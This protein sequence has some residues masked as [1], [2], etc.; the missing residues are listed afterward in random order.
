MT[1]PTQPSAEETGAAGAGEPA[2]REGLP[3]DAAS[4]AATEEPLA[5]R[6]EQLDDPRT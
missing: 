5:D 2:S 1:E 4:A 6:G 3:D